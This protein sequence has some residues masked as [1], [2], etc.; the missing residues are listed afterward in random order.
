M[1]DNPTATLAQDKNVD[2]FLSVLNSPMNEYD[3]VATAETLI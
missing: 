2:L 3:V 1:T